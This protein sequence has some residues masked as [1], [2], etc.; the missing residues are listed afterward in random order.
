MITPLATKFTNA[1]VSRPQTAASGDRYQP[2]SGYDDAL[3]EAQRY[4]AT[5]RAEQARCHALV[6][7]MDKLP[8]AQ[9]MSRGIAIVRELPEDQPDLRLKAATTLFKGL[10][11]DPDKRPV[12]SLA[13]AVLGDVSEL[14]QTTHGS[15]VEQCRE[16]TRAEKCAGAPVELALAALEGP[17]PAPSQV[18]TLGRQMMNQTP[19]R[20][21]MQQGFAGIRVLANVVARYDPEQKLECTRELVDFL[22]APLGNWD[23]SVQSP[24]GNE[25]LTGLTNRSLVKLEEVLNLKQLHESVGGPMGDAGSHVVV[26]GVR[27][28][29]RGG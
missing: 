11:D 7:E 21:G 6:E 2:A 28:R 13:L 10:V 19:A 4:L 9:L 25:L 23:F 15:I 29:K 3:V 27:L 5:L 8:P 18:V 20:E 14:P 12:A 17:R 1:C 22:T 16:Q 24:G 26:G